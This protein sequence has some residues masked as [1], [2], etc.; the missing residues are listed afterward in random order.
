MVTRGA[1]LN[2]GPWGVHSPRQPGP[3]QPAEKASKA[4]DRLSCKWGV[5]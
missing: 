4:E 1:A 3:G 5:G 2:G